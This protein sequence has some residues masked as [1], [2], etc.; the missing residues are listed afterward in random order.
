V[1]CAKLCINPVKSPLR[2]GPARR[3]R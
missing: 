1:E 3:Y 2:L